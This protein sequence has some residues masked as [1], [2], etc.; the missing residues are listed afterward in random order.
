MSDLKY[1]DR[2]TEGVLGLSDHAAAL[3]SEIVTLSKEVERQKV[4]IDLLA[5]QY[6]ES[7]KIHGELA[8][9][10]KDV[11]HDCKPAIDKLY[12]ISDKVNEALI[13]HTPD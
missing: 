11:L 13:S 3:E 5:A 1:K 10:I 12:E 4:V 2:L 9:D 6:E 7:L 8:R